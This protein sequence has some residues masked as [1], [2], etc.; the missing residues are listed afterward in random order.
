VPVW[1]KK[2][3]QDNSREARTS[4]WV[5]DALSDFN[6]QIQARDL[7]RFVHFAAER[8]GQDTRW[9]DRILT[10]TAIRESLPACSAQKV[11]EISKENSVLRE[12]FAALSENSTECHF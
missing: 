2:L 3:G 12:V 10:P 7:V 4:A 9:P 11:E 8:S 1:G 5:L 6:G